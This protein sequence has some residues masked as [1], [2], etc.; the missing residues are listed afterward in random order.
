M[1]SAR[2]VSRASAILP[3]F[4]LKQFI[5]FTNPVLIHKFLQCEILQ[6]MLH[7][8]TAFSGLT[9]TKRNREGPSVCRGAKP[10]GR[11]RLRP[12]PGIAHCLIYH[13]VPPARL[14]TGRI[15]GRQTRLFLVRGTT[16]GKPEG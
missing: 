16:Q 4:H 9:L 11:A 7:R 2:G 8:K 1:L 6:R 5:T 10:F 13:I 15:T 14:R 12:M 3:S